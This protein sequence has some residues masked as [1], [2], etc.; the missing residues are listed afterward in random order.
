MSSNYAV[1]GLAMAAAGVLTDV[2][3]AR[4]VT[5][6][7]PVVFGFSGDPVEGKL[8]ASLA[9][10]GGSLTGIS[11]MQFELIGKRLEVLKEAVPGL[12]RVPCW[13]TPDTREYRKSSPDH[14]PQRGASGSSCSTC[15]WLRY[16][17]SRQPSKPWRASV[18]RRSWSF[19]TGS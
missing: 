11:L 16:T 17:T 15:P 1:L 3:G 14:R 18:P 12:T 8:V 2:F 7:I 6:P 4:A 13:P 9:R 5:G 19:P 10:P